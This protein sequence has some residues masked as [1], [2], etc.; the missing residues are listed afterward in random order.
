MLVLSRKK[1]QSIVINDDIE[2][3][4]VDVVNDQVKIGIRA[5]QNVTVHR[6]EVYDNIKNEMTQAA[7]SD[8]GLKNLGKI[9]LPG[10]KPPTLP[11]PP[12][13]DKAPPATGGG[14]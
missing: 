1:N 5:P 12:S 4:V 9:K 14:N 8:E 3:F 7:M 10:A 6:K 2:I 11:Q 13:P